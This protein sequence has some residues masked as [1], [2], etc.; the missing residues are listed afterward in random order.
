MPSEIPDPVR[1]PE[2]LVEREAA[3]VRV[4][5]NRPQKKNALTGPMY[6]AMA[7][8]LAD[9]AR[10]DSV[11]V[12]ILAGVDGCFSA[13]NDL[14]AFMNPSGEG[15]EVLRFL[16][17]ITHFPKPLVAAVGGMAIGIGTTMLLHCDYVVA[18][19]DAWFKMPFTELALV[20]EA[21]SSLMI[22]TLLGHRVAGEILLLSEPFDAPRAREWGIVNRVEPRPEVERVA[23]EISA[24]FASLPA[25]S[26]QATK[27]LLRRST[28]ASVDETM[29]REIEAFGERLS[30]PE[31]M[32]ALQGFMASRD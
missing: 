14:G 18:A 7:D 17:E 1:G 31:F 16:R 12:V 27:A 26:V 11:R 32:E 9:A 19:Q 22:P 23:H 30:S 28:L 3:L 8:A 2:I 13:G 6:G 5:M 21:A 24:R 29:A 15:S 25:G 4:R 20:P 10:D